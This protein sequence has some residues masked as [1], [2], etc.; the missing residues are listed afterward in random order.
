VG[1]LWFAPLLGLTKNKTVALQ[2]CEVAVG[3]WDLRI[4][5]C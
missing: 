4:V 1:G 3:I 5:D 2:W